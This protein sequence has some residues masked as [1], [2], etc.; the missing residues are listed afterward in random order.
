[1]E[2]KKKEHWFSPKGIIK[3]TKS[4]Q[5]LKMRKAKD[6]SDGVLG[7]FGKVVFCI[8]VFG[9]IFVLIDALLSFGMNAAGLL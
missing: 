5:F 4:I 2:K 1:M 8:I 9:L 7:K 6:G 3:N